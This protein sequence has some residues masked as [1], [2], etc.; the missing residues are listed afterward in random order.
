MFRRS[1]ALTA[2]MAIASFALGDSASAFRRS[3]AAP[4]PSAAL[5]RSRAA[6]VSTALG[7]A[8][9]DNVCCQYSDGTKEWVWRRICVET[10][11]ATIV[12]DRECFIITESS[13]S[14]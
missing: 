2:L 8:D 11:N 3:A 6:F 5:H 4:K 7:A 1:L 9:D 10:Q 13:L 14:D 12:P